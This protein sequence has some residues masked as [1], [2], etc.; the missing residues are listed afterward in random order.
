MI[1]KTTNTLG[2]EVTWYSEDEVKHLNDLLNQALKEL[3]ELQDA[4]EE[5]E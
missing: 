4:Y 1:W 3:E 2:Q 5:R